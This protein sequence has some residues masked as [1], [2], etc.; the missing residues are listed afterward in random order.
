MTNI[1]EVKAIVN[2]AI[3]SRREWMISVSKEALLCPETGFQEYQTAKL[4]G[5]KLEEL[6]IRHD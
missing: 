6:G 2:R 5:Q 4:V 1:E 3:D